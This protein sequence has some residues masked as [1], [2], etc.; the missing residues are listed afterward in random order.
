[1]AASCHS[2]CVSCSPHKKWAEGIAIR[3]AEKFLIN[4]SAGSS[5]AFFSASHLALLAQS[6]YAKKRSARADSHASRN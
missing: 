5:G 4:Q 6:R 2:C 1:M 3:N